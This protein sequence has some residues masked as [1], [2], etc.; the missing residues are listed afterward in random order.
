MYAEIGF[1]IHILMFFSLMGA[2]TYMLLNVG[3]E[4]ALLT[5]FY[6]GVGWSAV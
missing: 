4:A 6:R 1:H 5:A 2:S 3:I